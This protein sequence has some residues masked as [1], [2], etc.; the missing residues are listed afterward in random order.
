M[1]NVIFIEGLPG[2]GKTTYAKRISEFYENQ[3]YQVKRFFEGDLHPIDL[4]WCGY[5][6]KDQ[7]EAILT[8]YPKFKEKIL[9][10]TIEE[11][12]KYI[13]AY[14][15]VWHEETTQEF[16]DEMA[17]YEVYQWDSKEDFL[18]V[19]KQ[20]WER[21][22]NDF[23][24]NTVYVFECIFLQNHITELILK[25]N[26]SKT[27]MISYFKDLLEK[28]QKTNPLIFYIYQTDIQT[29]LERIIEERRTTDPTRNRDWIE[30]VNLFLE[31]T[32]YGKQMGYTGKDGM[33]KYGSH[34]QNMEID[35]LQSLDAPSHIFSLKYDYEEVFEEMKQI[36]I[37]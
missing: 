6:N 15:R 37:E 30:N 24:P 29:T 27:E 32:K 12:G 10:N 4:A 7:M 1:H 2:S 13:I 16:Y 34:R 33:L 3:G 5:C 31:N 28:I 20:R 36:S 19:H 9:E 25:H 18:N 22:A 14:T 21:F 23:D 8:K 26:A 35:I 17:K 11:N